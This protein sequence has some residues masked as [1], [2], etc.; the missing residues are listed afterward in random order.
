M[1]AKKPR[2]SSKPRSRSRS[3]RARNTLVLRNTRGNHNKEYGLSIKGT[4]VTTTWGPI[5]GWKRAQRKKF[6]SRQEAILWAR[7]QAMKKIGG[8]YDPVG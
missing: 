6:K 5:G 2:K 8:G 4:V 7:R 3:S 1:P